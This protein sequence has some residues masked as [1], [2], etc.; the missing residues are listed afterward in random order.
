MTE[1]VEAASKQWRR[2]QRNWTFRGKNRETVGV[3]IAPNNT[4]RLRVN[5][6][7]NRVR[8]GVGSRRGTKQKRGHPETKKHLK[9]NP[10]RQNK[11]KEKTAGNKKTRAKHGITVELKRTR[12][13]SNTAGLRVSW[14]I[15]P[16]EETFC[17]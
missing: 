12:N 2:E 8:L 7:D 4:V 13:C 3:G 16:K 1:G 6:K 5:Q 10:C 9:S 11:R 15:P 17:N 14:G